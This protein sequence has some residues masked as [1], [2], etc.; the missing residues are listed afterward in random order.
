VRYFLVLL[1]LLSAAAFADDA[2]NPD[3]VLA[4][5]DKTNLNLFYG[6]MLPY[7]IYGAR[8]VYP[9]W[10]AR[11]SQEIW[12][13]HPEFSGY[14]TNAGNVS[15][16]MGALSFIAP[17]EFGGF[18]FNPTFG[19]DLAYYSG[20][21]VHNKLPFTADAGVHLGVS[22]VFDISEHW[23]LRVDFTMFINPGMF[24]NVDAGLNYTF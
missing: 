7:G 24:L 3:D 6:R 17:F 4:R 12:G 11:Y 2:A 10:G 19:F 1:L 5:F 9:Y 21:T 14:L 23:A 8:E 15:F 20:H 16:Y 18:A 13:I 22:P